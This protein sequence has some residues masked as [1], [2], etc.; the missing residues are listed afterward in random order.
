MKCYSFYKSMP[1]AVTIINK[2]NT[3]VLDKTSDLL[4]VISVLLVNYDQT[5]IYRT[6]NCKAYLNYVD[7]F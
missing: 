2:D 3:K 7:I 4:W 1:D 6:N 5:T